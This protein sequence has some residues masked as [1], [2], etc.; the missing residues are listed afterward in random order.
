MAHPQEG[1]LAEPA[2][3]RTV[4]V[5]KLFRNNCSHAVRISAE[6]E[7]SDGRAPIQKDGD[8]LS[9]KPEFR[10]RLID[11][12]R[13]LAPLDPEDAFPDDLHDCLLSLR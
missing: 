7:C 5:A 3:N 10:S 2:T 13:G 6:S 4:R 11:T 8:R 12:L 9:I 1:D